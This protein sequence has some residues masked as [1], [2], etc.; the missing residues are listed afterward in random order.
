MLNKDK[1][2]IPYRRGFIMLVIAVGFLV[3]A[4]RAYD[5]QVLH[6][7]FLSYQGNA[8][9]QRTVDVS[10]YRG[11]ITD[12]NGEPLA[13]STP[14]DS[15]WVNPHEFLQDSSA[16]FTLAQ[17]LELDPAILRKKVADS[18]DREFLYIKR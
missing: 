8:R 2:T 10:A 16:L 6:R 18:K 9:Q 3:L 15:V 11:T 17:K 5:L 13:I 4:A 12:R 14:V 1:V 7:D